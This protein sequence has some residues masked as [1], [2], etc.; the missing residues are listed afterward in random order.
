MDTGT[1]PLLS[2]TRRDAY[3]QKVLR[4]AR[5]TTKYST[6]QPTHMNRVGHGEKPMC[7]KEKCL[8]WRYGPVIECLPNMNRVLGLTSG[9]SA[10]HL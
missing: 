4:K 5:K 1:V 8:G 6:N 3:P 10:E 9:I 7:F 2:F